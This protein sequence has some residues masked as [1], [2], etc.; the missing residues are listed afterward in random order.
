V[1]AAIGR[2]RASADAASALVGQGQSR[3]ARHRLR[4]TAGAL[5]TVLHRLNSRL[6]R[7][8]V[9]GEV[10]AALVARTVAIRTSVRDALHDW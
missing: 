3:A 6:A 5:G 8:Q 4:R 9:L 10:R 7:R 2:A 1:T